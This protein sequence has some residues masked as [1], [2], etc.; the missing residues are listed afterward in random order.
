MTRILCIDDEAELREFLEETLAEAGYDTASASNGQEALELIASFS[1]DLVVSDLSM[2]EMNGLELLHVVRKEYPRF[3]DVPFILLTGHTD[4]NAVIKGLASGADD[5]LTKP[6]DVSHLLAKIEAILRQV[7]RMCS[8]KQQEH[9]K[10]YKALAGPV[11]GDDQSK[12]DSEAPKPCVCLIGRSEPSVDELKSELEQAGL[13]VTYIPS[14]RKFL[15]TIDSYA[16]VVTLISFFTEDVQGNL[17]ARFARSKRKALGYP[18]ILLWPAEAARVPQLVR[19]DDAIDDFIIL[20]ATDMQDR[21][22][23]WKDS[24]QNIAVE[25]EALSHA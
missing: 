17:V 12:G 4:R 19:D 14:G 3:A 8:K 20:P 15:D 2:P 1:P 16:P 13:A 5:Y 7:S 25:S 24:A 18:M 23:T 6:V 9:I 21:I 22:Q 11:G 10:L